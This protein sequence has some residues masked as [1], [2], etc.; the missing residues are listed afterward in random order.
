MT[1]AVVSIV[2][3][4]FDLARLYWTEQSSLMTNRGY[5]FVLIATNEENSN[6]LAYVITNGIKNSISRDEV[7]GLLNAS[8]I[9]TEIRLH[10]C[11]SF[12][13]LNCLIYL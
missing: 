13:F 3:Y 10:F 8:S 6:S 1:S 7:L 11:L 9:Y 4:C 5:E 2:L 12:F